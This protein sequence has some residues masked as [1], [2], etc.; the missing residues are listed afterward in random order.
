[1]STNYIDRSSDE[2]IID[3]VREI[4]GNGTLIIETINESILVELL[5]KRGTPIEFDKSYRDTE[6]DY[7]RWKKERI[8]QP[9][10]P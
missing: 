1:M 6:E 3:I 2:E 9:T 10:S 4:M 7:E 5:K 8:S